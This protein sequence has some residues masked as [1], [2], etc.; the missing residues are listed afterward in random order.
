[1]DVRV[2]FR[3]NKSTGQVEVFEI[4]DENST[5]P[6]AEHN[7]EHDRIAAEIGRVVER[8]PLVI[9]MLP[10][11][12]VVDPPPRQRSAEADSQDE[13]GQLHRERQKSREA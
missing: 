9:E 10:G 11:A 2:K 6:A 5:L 7:R 8:N 12:S 13:S 3:F 4:D 1:M